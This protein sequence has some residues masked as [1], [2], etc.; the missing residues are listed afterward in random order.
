MRHTVAFTALACVFTSL[1][2]V[3]CSS[4][5]STGTT[6]GPSPSSSSPT[7]P[8]EE[9]TPGDTNNNNNNNNKDAG[10]DSGNPPATC[11]APS[12]AGTK[13]LGTISASEKG[14]LCD[15]S[16]CPFGGYGKS[17]TC[18]GGVS[19]KAKA[20]QSACTSDPTWGRCAAL[21]VA[22]YLTCQTK[23]NE[24]PCNALQVMMNDAACASFKTCAL[25][26]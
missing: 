12:V 26:N 25:G 3:A 19:A 4:D 8:P 17:K 23:L 18:G 1:S 13:T 2:L 9:S 11:N 21:S 10:S 22:D 7:T 5:D 20:S 24:E 16:A 15:Y 14:S 6:A